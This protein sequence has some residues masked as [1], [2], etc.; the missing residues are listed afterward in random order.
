MKRSV[1]QG[2]RKVPV[3]EVDEG[4]LRAHVSEVVRQSVGE[5]LNGLL[6]AEAGRSLAQPCLI[7]MFL[8]MAS[9]SSVHGAAK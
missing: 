3:I 4:R 2:K 8:W 5:T 9:G 6:E 7:H 1:E